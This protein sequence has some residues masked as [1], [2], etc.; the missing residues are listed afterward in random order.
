MTYLLGELLQVIRYGMMTRLDLGRTKEAA[1]DVV[2]LLDHAAPALQS[3]EPPESVARE[4]LAVVQLLRWL[5]K[6]SWG[7]MEGEL[8][9]WLELVREWV[10]EPDGDGA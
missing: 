1:A 8:G 2:R 9:P 10:Q 4:V 3:D 5:S 7:Q 6:E